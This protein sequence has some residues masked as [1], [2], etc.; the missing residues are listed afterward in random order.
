MTISTLFSIKVFT[1]Y[2]QMIYIYH[3]NKINIYYFKRTNRRKS[4]AKCRPAME[5]YNN[6]LKFDY[7]VRRLIKRHSFGQQHHCVWVK[8][9]L[10][11]GSVFNHP[12]ERCRWSLLLEGEYV[13]LSFG[14]LLLLN[15]HYWWHN[16]CSFQTLSFSYV[17]TSLP[18]PN[19]NSA[20]FASKKATRIYSSQLYSYV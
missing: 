20:L 17:D 13:F 1:T 14:P 15:F 16:A 9:K 3:K 7:S 12:H 18:V 8:V 19:K 2:L 4:I 6:I 5:K 11:S 10:Y